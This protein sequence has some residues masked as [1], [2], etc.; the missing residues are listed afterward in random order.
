MS[1]DELKESQE[2]LVDIKKRTELKKEREK[3]K[4]SVEAY[5]YK[6]QLILL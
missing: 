6:V 4:N 5:I 1:S 3:E 2:K